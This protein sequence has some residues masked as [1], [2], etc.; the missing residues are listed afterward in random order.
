[1]LTMPL[2]LTSYV[3]PMMLCAVLQVSMGLPLELDL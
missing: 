3:I 2:D 1:M